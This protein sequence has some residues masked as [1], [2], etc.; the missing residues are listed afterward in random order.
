M[1]IGGS[2]QIPTFPAGRETGPQILLNQLATLFRSL[3]RLLI[4]SAD[5]N[6]GIFSCVPHSALLTVVNVA[7]GIATDRMGNQ[8]VYDMNAAGMIVHKV[9]YATRSKSSLQAASWTTWIKYNQSLNQD[10]LTVTPEGN[11]IVKTYEDATNTITFIG[12]P[13]ARRFGLLKSMTRLPG[14]SIGIPSRPGS[15]GQTQLTELYFHDPIFNQ[16]CATIEVRGNPIDASGDYFPPQNGG[17]APTNADRSRYATII[18][19]DYQKDL[20][21]DI[22]GDA[23]L[24]ALL[25]PTLL[26]ADANANIGSLISFVN[27]QMVATDGT[28]GIPAGFQT[29]L[30]DINGDGTGAGT[31]VKAN[32]AGNTVKMA[33]PP[34]RQLVPT[35]TT[36]YSQAVLTDLPSPTG[37]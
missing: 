33:Q 6:Y 23:T 35:T 32:H 27:N 9:A 11:S 29:G 14:N 15:N 19:R 10:V 2:I 3:I 31:G 7:G 5:R 24:Q 16:P 34:V 4:D 13:Y 36:A 28:G 1:F 12:V 25:F 22:Q 30:G 37:G 18:Y 21:A 20:A 17:A 8:T 26:P